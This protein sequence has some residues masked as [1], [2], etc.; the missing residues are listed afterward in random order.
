M[1]WETLNPE[2]RP[3]R[4]KV[5][6]NY[7]SQGCADSSELSCQ[8]ILE[9]GQR[10]KSLVQ[11]L[12]IDESIGNQAQFIY[13]DS[14]QIPLDQCEITGI[15]DIRLNYAIQHLALDYE[16][17]LPAGSQ[18]DVV[19]AGGGT[20]GAMAAI[21]A[22]EKEAD[23]TTVE[24]FPELGG[25]KT[26]GGVMGYYWG[27]KDTALF[28]RIERAVKEQG[29]VL[30]AAASR[31]AMMFY[32]RKQVTQDSGKLLTNS[33][34]CGVTKDRD[35]VTGLIVERDGTLTILKGKVIVDATGDGDV[36]VFAGAGWESGDRRM[37]A[38]QNYS[39]WDINPGGKAW[40]D[41]STNRDYD[42][43]MNQYQ[44]ELQR[45]YRLTHG[46]SHHYDFMPML[47]VRESRRIIGEYTITLKD[48][49][50]DKH[51]ADTI[52]LAYSD[53]DPHHFGDTTPTRVGCLLPH[54]TSAVV[55]I[56]Y[57]AL[58]PK[59]VRGLL[60]SAKAISQTH[61][62]LQLTRMSFDIMTQGY[63]TGWIA[64]MAAR[65]E[66]DLRD[67]NVDSIRP[68]L[69]ELRILRA[70]RPEKPT[71]TQQ[72]L[73]QLVAG[74]PDSLICVLALPREEVEPVLV[75]RL[76]QSKDD[77]ASLRLA[78]ALAWFGNPIGNPLIMREMET[79][80]AAE[81]AG[82]AL[83]WEYYRKDKE[84]DYW[85]INQDIALLAMSG[86]RAVL[87]AILAIAD[88][89]KLNNPPVRQETTYNRGRIDLTLVP[90]Y[91]R[92]I[93]VCFAIELMPDG[94]AI[95][96]LKRFLDDPYIQGHVTETPEQAGTRVYGG[97]LESRLAATLA[98]CG[99]KWGLD[100]LVDYIDDVHYLLAHYARQELS[101]IV[102]KDCGYNRQEWA[103]HIAGLTFPRP[104]RPR[105]ADSI[106]W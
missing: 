22:I 55:E 65:E 11:D 106:E 1:A 26:L 88:S 14:G 27:Y 15:D 13:H 29:K 80:Y 30:G 57:R 70:P 76:R 5:Y 28:D 46:Q 85:T 100:V 89:L 58:L 66:T 12:P 17:H 77:G 32:L 59:D 83:P 10:A 91:N 36:A 105:R 20:A 71:G 47:T 60:V 16:K 43:L 78:K 3:A 45:G 8:D 56:P 53:Y 9:I 62:A 41:S 35:R 54:G 99:D 39:Q 84:T 101:A 34:V 38:T 95:R 82:G 42:I 68:S 49:I 67:F 21:G 7:V 23:V 50:G 40:A 52:C 93:N 102:E 31:V 75:E 19:V 33:I 92:I 61:N 97:I 104:P 103:K 44:S 87:P 94:R 64:A 74:G 72:R 37:K 18:S 86:D 6:H 69:V 90:Y 73:D 63:V 2:K 79:L 24:Y 51:H 25:T 4:R 96:T 98:R 48:V 81:Q